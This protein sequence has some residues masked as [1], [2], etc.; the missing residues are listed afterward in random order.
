MRYVCLHAALALPV[1][2]QTGPAMWIWAD[3]NVYRPGEQ[4]TVRATLDPEGDETEYTLFAYRQNNQTGERSFLPGGS[5]EPTDLS[6]SAAAQGFRAARLEARSKSILATVAAPGQPGM[7][8]LALQ[9]RDASARRIIRTAYFKMG[10]VRDFVDAPNAINSDTTWTND[11]AYRI[12][13]IV[14]VGG[15]ATLT[16]EPGTFVIGQPGSQPPSVLLITTAGRISAR[17]TRARPIIMTSSQPVGSRARSDW[18]GLIMLGRAPINDPGTLPIEGLPDTAETRFGGSS[19]DHNC[20]ALA[21]VRVEFAGAQLR[22]NE[23]TNSFTWGGCGKGT[24]AEYLQSHYGF[25]DAFEWFGGNN[26]AKHLVGTYAADDFLDV[27]IGYTGRVQHV[28]ALANGDNSNR[29]I[30]VDNYERDFDAQPIGTW[31]VWNVTCIGNGQS[32][33][34]DETDA[35]GLYIRRGGA[36]SYRN[37]L[38]ANWQT[39]AVG[40]ANDAS[41]L[42]RI[43]AGLLS[44]DGLL[45]FG[46]GGLASDL[47]N[48]VAAGFQPFIGGQGANPARNVVFADP[49]LRRPLRYSDPDFRPAV[50]SPVFNV[51]WPQSAD[52]F[53]D[54]SANWSG[55][56]GDRDW[57]EEWSTFTQEE[58]LKP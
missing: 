56:F 14:S 35:A 10:I 48:Q 36:G 25:D 40:I 21:Y 31:S 15:N 50:G 30:E 11:R 32:R 8:T 23:E 28:V 29:C 22:P 47:Q 4:I 12:R 55:A 9:V 44:L 46:S 42:P 51:S 20:G 16:I 52:D 45:T 5:M 34:F 33:G 53:F 37:I 58:D 18:G 43:G 57:T 19:A 41:V 26:D 1:W 6:G 7:H 24:A 49:M 54:Q 39:R 13:G 2:A 27:Q 17:G 38:I 3:K